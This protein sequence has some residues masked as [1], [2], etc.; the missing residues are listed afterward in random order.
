[1][2]HLSDL[3]PHSKNTHALHPFTVLSMRFA[4]HVAASDSPLQVLS[5][6]TADFP[7]VESTLSDV[8][9]TQ[10]FFEEIARNQATQRAASAPSFTI[11][12][13]AQPLTDSLDPFLLLRVMRQ[14][15][16]AVEDLL[17]LSD[18]LTGQAARDLLIDGSKAAEPKDPLDALLGQLFDARDAT[19]GGDTILWWNDLEKDG[20]Y[21]PW[22]KSVREV[23]RPNYPGQMTLLARNLHNVVLALNLSKP[24]QLKFVVDYV[25][26]FIAR[27][28]PV[29]FG[30]VPVVAEEGWGA[31][32]PST[33][34]ALVMWH[35]VDTVGRSVALKAMGEVCRHHSASYL[36]R[37]TDSPPSY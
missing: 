27:N 17:S 16:R 7:L 3:G 26:Q 25:S 15:R 37:Q 14:E 20:R 34:V 5:Q 30:V 6:G 33:A 31:H 13:L 10:P 11:N 28:I 32:E 21:K 36:M 12:G 2:R 22:A 24:D 18:E 1:M 19:E 4:Q 9:I 8:E 23:L 29:R 35:L